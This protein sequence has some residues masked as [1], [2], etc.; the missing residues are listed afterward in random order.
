M[1]FLQRTHPLQTCKYCGKF[2]TSSYANTP[3][4]RFALSAAAFREVLTIFREAG[5]SYNLTKSHSYFP[6]GETMSNFEYLQIS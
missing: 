6:H 5:D 4:N 2:V 1:L 3:T